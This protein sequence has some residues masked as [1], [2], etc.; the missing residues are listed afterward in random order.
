[1]KKKGVFFKATALLLLSLIISS[2]VTLSASAAMASLPEDSGAAPITSSDV[3]TDLESAGDSHTPESD[4][5]AGDM[6]VLLIIL[7]SMSILAFGSLCTKLFGNRITQKELVT[8]LF[9]LI[10]VI[11]VILIALCMI[12]IG[13]GSGS[14]TALASFNELLFWEVI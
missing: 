3:T 9:I 13:K 6:T 2:F 7:V 5:K 4:D 12:F 1:M 8:L 14:A 10:F 11:I